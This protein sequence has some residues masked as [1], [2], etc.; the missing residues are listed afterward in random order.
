MK[1]LVICSI[2]TALILTAAPAGGQQEEAVP[3]ES[4]VRV[5]AVVPESAR[6]AS[7]LGTEREGNGVIIDDDGLILTIGYLILEAAR[8]KVIDSAENEI[9]AVYVGYDHPSGLGLLRARGAAGKPVPMGN[10][11]DVSEGDTVFV[12]AHGGAAAVQATR[13]ISRSE[14]AGYWEYLLDTALYTAPAQSDYGGAAL[15]S[16]EGRLLGIGSIFTQ[17]SF[18]GIG[19][20]PCNMFVPI[21]LLKPILKDL[22][23]SGRTRQPP[24]PWLGLHVEETYGRVIVMRTAAEGPAER[25]GLKSGDIILSVAGKPIRSLADFYRKVWA[26]GNAGVQVPLG[27]LQGETIQ[28]KNIPSEDRR[29]YLKSRPESRFDSVRKN[30]RSDPKSKISLRLNQTGAPLLQGPA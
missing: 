28:E 4:M 7:S 17:L 12:V 1:N 29:R 27:V 25:A 24:R 21:D 10:S 26:L 13:V 19:A 30:G 14:F 15:I 18:A 20:I 3:H 23:H 22:V 9:D 8:I 5:Q 16:P 11:A 6:T 2:L